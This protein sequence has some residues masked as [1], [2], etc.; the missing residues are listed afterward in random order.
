MSD[1]HFIRK[2][3]RIIP[4]RGPKS[5]KSSLKKPIVRAK[6]ESTKSLVFKGAAGIGTGAYLSSFAGSAFA[7]FGKEAVHYAEAG[8]GLFRKGRGLMEQRRNIMAGSKIP[9]KSAAYLFKQAKTF[10]RHGAFL[11]TKS[12]TIGKVGFMVGAGALVAGSALIDYGMGK[13]WKATKRT[14]KKAA[15]NEDT[16]RAVFET[17]VALPVSLAAYQ[18]GVKRGLAKKAAVTAIAAIMKAR[19]AL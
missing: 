4:I 17:A 18:Y 8:K 2:H 19:R 13:A 15:K 12:G 14:F 6:H 5:D 16:K 9:E 11:R 7:E 3:G 10:T 1:V